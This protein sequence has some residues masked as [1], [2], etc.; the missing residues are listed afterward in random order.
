MKKWIAAILTL[1]MLSQALPWTAFAA[2]GDPITAAELQRALQIAGFRP[3]SA[4]GDVYRQTLT[5]LTG[6]ETQETRS[7][8]TAASWDFKPYAYAC[9]F[10]GYD[11]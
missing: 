5:L 7:A 11:I 2:T 6:P 4:G 1:V 3:D 8:G 9:T 10:N